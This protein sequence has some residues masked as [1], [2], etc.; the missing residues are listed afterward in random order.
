MSVIPHFYGTLENRSEMVWL[1]VMIAQFCVYA[2]FIMTYYAHF[3]FINM[4]S[5]LPSYRNYS[6]TSSSE[7]ENHISNPGDCLFHGVKTQECF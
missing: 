6:W 4:N 1:P 3:V 7:T 5:C 2:L